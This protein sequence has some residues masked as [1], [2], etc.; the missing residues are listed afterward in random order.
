MPKDVTSSAPSP[1]PLL[2]TGVHLFARN[3]SAPPSGAVLAAARPYSGA[4]LALALAVALHSAAIHRRKFPVIRLLTDAC[5]LGVLLT[6]L[7]QLLG[8]RHDIEFNWTSRYRSS[9]L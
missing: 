3:S 9:S 8:R 7:F 4:A 2:R 5:A 1:A 6:G